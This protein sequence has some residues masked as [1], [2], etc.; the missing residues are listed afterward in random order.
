MRALLAILF[1]L[2]YSGSAIAQNEAAN[3]FFGDKAGLRFQSDTVVV[4][5]NSAMHAEAGCAVISDQFGK[6]QFYTNGRDVWNSTHQKMPNGFGLN[7]SQILNQNSLIVPLPG[8]STI[9]YLFTIN[10]RYDSVGLNYSI[11]NMNLDNGLG[12]IEIKNRF[13]YAGFIEKITAAKHCNDKDIWI[14]AHDREDGYYSFLLTADGLHADTIRSFTGNPVRSDIGYMKMS[15]ASNR[16]ALPLNR[17][18]QLVEVSL[19]HNRSGKVYNPIILFAKEENVYAYGLE[20]S[21]DGNLLYIATGGRAYNIWQYD[22]TQNTQEKINASAMLIAEGNHFAMQL[23]PDGKI[24]IARE[25]RNYLSTIHHPEQRGLQCELEENAIDL[26]GKASLMGLPNFMPFLF[27]KPSVS[28]ENPCLGDTSYFCFTQFF[29][30]DS[31]SWNFGDGSPIQTTTSGE[32]IAHLYTA[33]GTYPVELHI[34]HCGIIDT[35]KRSVQIFDK[36]ETFLGN[37]TTLCNSCTI[38]LDGGEG[39]DNWLWQDGSENRFYQ[40]QQSGHYRVLVTKNECIGTDSIFISNSSVKVVIPN[41]FTPNGDGLNDDFRAYSNEP[42][43]DFHLLVFNRKGGLIFE[44]R[45]IDNAWDGRYKGSD[46]PLGLFSWQ[47]SYSYDDE[48]RLINE[49]KRGTVTLIR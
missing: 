43:T 18:K 20:F 23:A 1:V 49:I 48:G 40:V 14:V 3:W 9:Y 16:I 5:T 4:L 24:Y 7:G 28:I 37:D 13:M 36:L 17:N 35:V 32:N 11:V 38:V 19:F 2:L 26:Q 29:A 25:N 42:L 34:Y 30:N 47:I 33:V 8:N 31:L 15:S 44:S 10:A 39:M 12:D 27:Y 22:L 45:Q 41:A 6:L 46:V 21:A